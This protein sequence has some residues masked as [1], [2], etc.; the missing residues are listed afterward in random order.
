MEEQINNLADA[1]NGLSIEPLNGDEVVDEAL[2]NKYKAR[3]QMFK[4]DG[5]PGATTCYME[6][7]ATEDAN[8]LTKAIILQAALDIC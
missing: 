7:L 3:F 8:D 2:V 6:K 4:E 5:V 1:I